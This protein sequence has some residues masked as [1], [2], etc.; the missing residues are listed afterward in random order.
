MSY[1]LFGVFPYI[2]LTIMI[3]VSIIRYEVDPFSWKSKSSQF[4][5]RRHLVVGSVLFHVGVLVIFFGHL[6][7]LLTPFFI[8]DL[9][10]L[11][12]RFHQILAMV[13][14]GIAGVIALI[15]A[16]MLL[17]RRMSDPRIRKTSSPGDIFILVLIVI[18]L[19]LGLSTIFVSAQHLD[20]VEMVKLMKWAQGIIYFGSNPAAHLE[21]VNILFKLHIIV[22]LLIF[23]SV[24][25]TR[26]VHIFSA[27]IRFLWRPGYQ[28]VRTRRGAKPAR[29]GL[30][31]MPRRQ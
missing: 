19:V 10:G 14:G 7:G 18:Q 25:F 20:G 17:H 2:A 15:G 4:L 11:S 3:L 5:R 23:A 21:G 28:V 27:P 31:P 22:G 12:D 30:E 8:M 13:S 29:S 1:F 24:P 9:I 16:G 26:L 6:V